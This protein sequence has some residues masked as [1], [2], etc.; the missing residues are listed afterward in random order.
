MNRT[1]HLISIVVPVYNVEKYISRCIDSILTQTYKFYEIILVDDDSP[2][3]C[4]QICDDYAERYSNIFVIHLKN[5]GAGVSDARN[6]GIKFARGKYIAFIDSDDYVHMTLLEV[7]KNALE[8]NGVKMSMCHY[9]KIYNSD[10]QIVPLINEESIRVVDELEAMD[11]LLNDTAYSACW[12]KLFDISLFKNVSYPVGK[13]NEDM[14]VMPII[15][16]NA[17]KIAMV[18]QALY[19][20]CQDAPSLV[21]AKFSYPK[22]DVVDATLFWKKHAETFYPG[23]SEKAHIHYLSSVITCCQYIVNKTDDYG[24]L[25]YKAYKKE[26]L[27]NYKVFISSK[28][29]SRNNRFKLILMKYGLFRV[30][31]YFIELLKIKKYDFGF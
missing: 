13:C 6:A 31:F 4:P 9:Q 22:L 28:Y 30:V 23:L 20:Y 26:I 27:N 7:L 10:L 18:P 19:F 29:T 8:D 17:I 1:E 15:I 14:F 12:A 11:M 2:D 21:R 5:T 3:N 16:K 24:I 25:K